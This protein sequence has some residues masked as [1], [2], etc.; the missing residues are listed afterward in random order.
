MRCGWSAC[1]GRGFFGD[2]IF[3]ISEG[4][5]GFRNVVEG[6]EGDACQ[7][8]ERLDRGR[9]MVIL[10]VHPTIR[11]RMIP[12]KIPMLSIATSRFEGPRPATKD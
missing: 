1:F 3:D 8:P 11:T 2:I 12:V 9:K 10:P 7:C 4:G 5:Y 6:S